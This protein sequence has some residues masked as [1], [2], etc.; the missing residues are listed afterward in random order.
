MAAKKN[1]RKTA[2]NAP[3]KNKVK[4]RLDIR[5]VSHIEVEVD[6]DLVGDFLEHLP[7]TDE[8]AD[9]NFG[10]FVDLDTLTANIEK[11]EIEDG[12]EV[13]QPGARKNLRV[14][15]LDD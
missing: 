7:M 3:K 8:A 13:E 9:S 1:D 15:Y 4:V 12:Q 2:L 11:V 6:E 10:V 14:G 5:L